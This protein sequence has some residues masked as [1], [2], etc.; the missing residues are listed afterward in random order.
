MQG[1]ASRT[2]TRTT[3]LARRWPTGLVK[4]HTAS[5]YK[6]SRLAIFNLA[7]KW[8]AQVDD[9]RSSSA[10]VENCVLLVVVVCDCMR[11]ESRSTCSFQLKLGPAAV[12]LALVCSKDALPTARAGC[13]MIFTVIVC[14]RLEPLTSSV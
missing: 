3:I 9:A 1:N 6:S 8:H 5:D 7:E 10:G 13:A 14:F 12:L 4:I 11:T 2:G